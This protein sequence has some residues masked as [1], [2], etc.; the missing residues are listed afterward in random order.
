MGTEKITIVKVDTQDHGTGAHVALHL[1][2]LTGAAAPFVRNNTYVIRCF[3]L[4]YCA[5]SPLAA[6]ERLISY[7]HDW[8]P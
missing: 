3:V 8:Q 5:V 2:V 6:L 4:Q 7:E 1:L